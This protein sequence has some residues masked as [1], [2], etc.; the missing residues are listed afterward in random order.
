[1][2]D[3]SAAG[4]AG[5]TVCAEAPNNIQVGPMVGYLSNFCIV[6]VSLF[7]RGGRCSRISPRAHRQQQANQCMESSRVGARQRHTA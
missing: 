5:L 4:A 1:V 2:N 3:V 6:I 7:T